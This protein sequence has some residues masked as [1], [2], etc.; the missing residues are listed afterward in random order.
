MTHTV[1]Q[2]RLP[3]C[4]EHVQLGRCPSVAA[5]GT[6]TRG[7]AV[8]EDVEVAAEPAEGRVSKVATGLV[9][10]ARAR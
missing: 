6:L 8:L 2:C 10:P 9:L 3:E 7:R 4:I 1:E 5:H